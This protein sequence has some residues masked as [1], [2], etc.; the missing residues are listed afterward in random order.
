MEVA[1]CRGEACVWHNAATE[2]AVYKRAV[3]VGVSED[4]Y[5]RPNGEGEWV[6]PEDLGKEN[7]KD[8]SSLEETCVLIQL[9]GS[10]GVNVVRRLPPLLSV[11]SALPEKP[12][13]A[14]GMSSMRGFRGLYRGKGRLH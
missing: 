8:L 11:T 1:W 14:G 13:C 6:S 3:R 7:L 4:G 5:Y 12:E 9:R 10:R 2:S